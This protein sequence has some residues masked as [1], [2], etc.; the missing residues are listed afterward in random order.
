MDNKATTKI[1]NVKTMT[2]AAV[3]K[4]VDTVFQLIQDEEPG[5]GSNIVVVTWAS[6][7]ENMNVQNPPDKDVNVFGIYK[8]V[9][10]NEYLIERGTEK[11]G[12]SETAPQGIHLAN[13]S[14]PV[15][16]SGISGTLSSRGKR[17]WSQTSPGH[18]V[19]NL[20]IVILNVGYSNGS[21]N[22]DELLDRLHDHAVDAHEEVNDEYSALSS[23]LDKTAYQTSGNAVDTWIS[24]FKNRVELD[25]GASDRGEWSPPSVSFVTFVKTVDAYRV[26]LAIGNNV[27]TMMGLSSITGGG[28]GYYDYNDQLIPLNVGDSGIGQEF[29]K[30]SYNGKVGLRVLGCDFQSGECGS[31]FT[32]YAVDLTK[33]RINEPCYL[34]AAASS[35]P[36]NQRLLRPMRRFRDEYL[37]K[38]P[39]GN[40]LHIQ[41]K[42]HTFEMW[43][44]TESSPE[45]KHLAKQSLHHLNSLVK[46]WRDRKPEV[47]TEEKIATFKELA[48]LMKERASPNLKK[49][50]DSFMSDV[51]SFDN[52]SLG[53]VLLL[54]S[55]KT[56]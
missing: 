20:G 13:E 7:G 16:P 37:N 29:F 28:Q 11:Y 2:Q 42:K 1:A 34:N 8:G 24:A 15:C 14:I 56:K 6:N 10:S 32:Y 23:T 35:S 38:L 26:V 45:M 36:A 44:L 21:E 39:K 22:E 46:T 5:W 51:D 4:Q 3:L 53:Q 30:E 48:S 19:I 43:T 18:G 55:E 50:I 12:V 9:A 41:Y 54:M 40:A 49:S 52:L 31:W 25:Y 47:I 17:I 33:I 27:K